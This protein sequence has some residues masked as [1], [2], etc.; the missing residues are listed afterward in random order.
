MSLLSLS[1]LLSLLSRPIFLVPPL[2]LP[3]PE[4]RESPGEFLYLLFVSAWYIPA[5]LLV[6][7][8]LLFY[9]RGKN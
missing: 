1:S 7:Y 8:L 4:S 6:V 5:I 3:S 2:D 9:K